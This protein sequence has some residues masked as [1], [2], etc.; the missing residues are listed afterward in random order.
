MRNSEPKIWKKECWSG[1]DIFRQV[2]SKDQ[3]AD[4]KADLFTD[5]SDE[6]CCVRGK[7]PASSR[8][9]V[10]FQKLPLVY[11]YCWYIYELQY[12]SLS[13]HRMRRN[14]RQNLH[15]LVRQPL[16]YISQIL[17]LPIVESLS[18]LRA[19]T[20]LKYLLGISEKLLGTPCKLTIVSWQY[21]FSISFLI[22]PMKLSKSFVTTPLTSVRKWW[23]GRPYISAGLPQ[24]RSVKKIWL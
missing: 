6:V 5:M 2:S 7:F 13:V 15:S 20:V 3:R 12:K 24:R 16:C 11:E 17:E 14:I 21:L 1:C 18:L 19:S 9:T 8:T 10:G 22:S 4:L 23:R